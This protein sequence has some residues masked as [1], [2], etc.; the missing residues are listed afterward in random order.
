MLSN[1]NTSSHH[2]AADSLMI[3]LAS[4]HIMMIETTRYEQQMMAPCSNFE[5]RHIAHRRPR[6]S[7]GDL[8]LP[9]LMLLQTTPEQLKEIVLPEPMPHRLQRYFRCGPL[10][11]PYDCESFVYDMNG[12]PYHYKTNQWSDDWDL[13]AIPA[14]WQKDPGC[15]PSG[16]TVLLAT[17][18]PDGPNTAIYPHH[19][20]IHLIDGIFISKCGTL[21]PVVATDMPNLQKGYG[22]TE[23]LLLK[24]H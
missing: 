23:L 20:A 11:Q 2:A 14:D 15:L 5:A 21:G 13:Y 19:F 24:P 4:A 22:G 8:N 6:C 1:Q 10:Q 16:S 7:D 3:R 18:R 12:A 9:F 17:T